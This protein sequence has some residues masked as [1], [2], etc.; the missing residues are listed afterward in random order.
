MLGA[1]Q[2]RAFMP[3]GDGARSRKQIESCGSASMKPQILP[4]PFWYDSS[5]YTTAKGQSL[6]E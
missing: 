5:N 3:A 4:A 2:W 6:K 1:L